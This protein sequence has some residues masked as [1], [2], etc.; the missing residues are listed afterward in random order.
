MLLRRLVRFAGAFLLAG[1]D[2][3]VDRLVAGFLAVDVDLEAW[4][5]LPVLLRADVV[6]PEV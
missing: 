6:F 5:V 3:L 1:L 4:L 2:L